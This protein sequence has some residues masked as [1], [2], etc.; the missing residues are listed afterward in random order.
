[1][2][3]KMTRLAIL[4]SYNRLYRLYYFHQDL[5]IREIRVA[6]FNLCRKAVES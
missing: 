5:E 3:T 4:R 6:L 1:M 2:A